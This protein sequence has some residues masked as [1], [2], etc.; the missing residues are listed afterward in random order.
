[1]SPACIRTGVLDQM[2][3]PVLKPSQ[4]IESQCNKT[5]FGMIT[6][7]KAYKGHK[8]GLAARITDRFRII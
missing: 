1:M 4:N 5:S 7:I 8:Q 6:R 2:S 3:N